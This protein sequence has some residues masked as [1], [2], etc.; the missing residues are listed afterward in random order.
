M[1]EFQRL[2][3]N[4]K[5]SNNIEL[6]LRASKE[7]DISILLK[8]AH[9]IIAD[10]TGNAWQIYETDDDSA[11]AGLGDLLSGF[12]SGMAAL[13]LASGKNISTES[14]AKY[15]L[16]HSYA[17]SQCSIGSSASKIGEELAKIEREIKMRQMS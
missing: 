9:S 16:M 10:S 14:F 13:E 2:F 8:G 17:A 3:P 7:F 6:A 4:L 1:N 12:V 5:E 15:V 11:R